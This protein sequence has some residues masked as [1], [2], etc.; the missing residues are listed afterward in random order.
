MA[1]D[2]E[3]EGRQADDPKHIVSASFPVTPSYNIKINKAETKQSFKSSILK[4][5]A[6]RAVASFADRTKGTWKRS[7]S[8]KWRLSAGRA[9]ETLRAF[10][11][12]RGTPDAPTSPMTR[13][14][15]IRTSVLVVGAAAVV[16]FVSVVVYVVYCAFTIPFGGGVALDN[17]SSAM[18]IA[19]YDSNV[20]ATRGNFRGEQLG[21]DEMPAKLEQAIVAIEDRRFFQHGGIDPRGIARAILRDATS[22]QAKEG[23]STITQQLSRLLFLSPDRN[24]RRKVQ[25]ALITIWLE[26][27]LSKTEILVKYLNT[28]Y[29]G[30]GA[31]GADGAARRYFNKSARDL[32][33]AEAAMLAGLVRAPSQLAPSKNIAGARQRA[34]LVLNAMQQTGVITAAEAQAA[35]AHPADL[36][37]PPDLPDDYGYISDLVSNEVKGLIGSG[38]TDLTVTTTIDK[39]LQAIAERVVGEYL[40]RDGDAKRA[41]Q[42]ALVALTSDGSIIALVGGRD[43]DQSQFNRATQAKRQGGSLF[44]LFVYMTALRKGLTPDTMLDDRPVKIGN[45]EPQNYENNFRGPVTA[46][47]AFAHSINTVA[48]DLGNSVGI[49][50]VIATA[51]SLGVKSDLPNVPSLALGTAGVTLLEM[52]RAYATATSDVDS[53]DPF[54]VRS[55]KGHSDM[56][57]R[58]PPRY[59]GGG[60]PDP[61]KAQ[62][63]DLLSAVVAEGTGK[64]ARTKFEV[65]GKTGTTQDFHDAWFIGFAPGLTAGVWVG[66][67]DNSPMRKETGGDLPARI[68]HDFVEGAQRLGQ[69]RDAARKSA[70]IDNNSR[71]SGQV[72]QPGPDA[73]PSPVVGEA[74]VVDTASLTIDDTPIRLAGI[75]PETGR[76]AKSLARYLSGKDIVCNPSETKGLFS[77][78]ADDKDLALT[79]LENGGASPTADAAPALR[80]AAASARAAHLGKWQ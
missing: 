54:L 33:L 67:D 51:R 24:L 61:A 50:N 58:R 55:I 35:I 4:S 19:A 46:R 21:A 2:A 13:R 71:P 59:P 41:S 9:Y 53:I 27:Q 65:G 14:R 28:A 74:S 23:A 3:D 73:K 31:Y 30:A 72:R 64:A 47:T 62:M 38:P 40:D 10:R 43:Y 6:W 56:L 78:V 25:E 66:N 57:F 17:P 29:F 26:H 77:C 36:K 18:V 34:V 5:A 63:R 49:P 37:L 45:W 48:A 7:G 75:Q 16:G 42:A 44:K 69:A 20:V 68:W 12:S 70:S 22:R 76:A 79:M 32:T 15:L 1:N 60:E 80:A 52:T 8:G 39:D 11:A